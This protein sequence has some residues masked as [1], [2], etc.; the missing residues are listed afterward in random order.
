MDGGVTALVRSLF[1]GGSNQCENGEREQDERL[2][3][4]MP[5]KMAR[6]LTDREI[7]KWIE[8]MTRID[9][10]MMD[11]VLTEGKGETKVRG[12]INNKKRCGD[13]KS[14]W[15]RYIVLH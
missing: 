3:P 14:K 13:V 2:N 10:W 1:D 6:V 15:E 11:D 5:I 9:G 12:D 7:Q 8:I 4:E